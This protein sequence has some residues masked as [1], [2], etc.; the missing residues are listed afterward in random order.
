MPGESFRNDWKDI[1]GLMETGKLDVKPLITHILPLSDAD[2]ALRIIFD[3]VKPVSAGFAVISIRRFLPI[4]S[5]ISRHYSPVLWSHQIIAFLSTFLS[6]S[7][8]TRP[9]I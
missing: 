6:S 7:S 3:A 5:S 4:V 1:L 2:R 9:C 8:I